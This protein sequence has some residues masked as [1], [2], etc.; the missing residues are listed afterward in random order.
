M[1]YST[2]LVDLGSTAG[3]NI[4][5][6]PLL[7]QNLSDFENMPTVTN[8][9]ITFGPANKSYNQLKN[10]TGP[11]NIT[12]STIYAQYL[13]QVLEEKPAGSLFVAILVADLVILQAMWTIT[14]WLT[15]VWLE[16]RDPR[17]NYCAGC[18]VKQEWVRD[19]DESVKNEDPS[20]GLELL[21]QS[22]AQSRLLSTQHASSE[23]Q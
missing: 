4:L 9:W 2:V 21:V 3:T 12:P 1:F 20:E 16:H 23:S 5:T 8:K 19:G 22:K 6:E 17:A 11:L 10:F 18:L 14:K 15:T 7:L 13:C